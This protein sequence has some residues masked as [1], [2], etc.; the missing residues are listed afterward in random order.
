MFPHRLVLE[1]ARS[2]REENVCEHCGQ[3]YPFR[4]L[5]VDC[6]EAEYTGMFELEPNSYVDLEGVQISCG[7]CIRQTRSGA[8]NADE[9]RLKIRRVV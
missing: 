5:L 3:P 7:D 6:T 4:N 8:Q 2:T 9:V 1:N